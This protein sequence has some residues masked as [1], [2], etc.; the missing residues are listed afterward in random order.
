[1]PAR[2]EQGSAAAR[3]LG[4]GLPRLQRAHA[5]LILYGL[6]SAYVV[7]VGRV[8]RGARLAAEPAAP[9][10]DWAVGTQIVV[11][12]SSRTSSTGAPA[13]AS[14]A[15][16]GELHKCHHRSRRRDGLARRLPV[17]WTEVVVY[18][19]RSTCRWPSS[20][21]EVAV[22]GLRHRALEPANLRSLVYVLNSL[23]MYM[24]HHDYEGDALHKN[25][26]IIFS[27]WLRQLHAGRAARI[28]FPGAET[29]PRNFFA[30]ARPRS[31]WSACSVHGADAA[32]VAHRRRLRPRRPLG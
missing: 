16:P 1:M 11:R 23:R 18:R 25:F 17:Q 8:P 10:G 32:G 26:G 19:C 2:P 6:A 28:G 15:A 22:P 3:R 4:R 27:C 5:G 20:A 12:S 30:A 13:A 31:R 14:G 7:D 29:Y 24:W 21:P 9:R